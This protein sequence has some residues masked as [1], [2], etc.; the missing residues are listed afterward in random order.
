MI[1]KRIPK[2]Y[3]I[4]LDQG[5]ELFASLEVFTE[6]HQIQSAYV[7]G[8][9][10]VRELELGYFDSEQAQYERKIY[11]ENLEVV[12]L[13]GT[14][15]ECEDKPF[16]HIHG[17]FGTKQFETVGGHVMRAVTDMTLE[18]FISD[19]ETRITRTLDEQSG[20]KLLN[21]DRYA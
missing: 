11:Q 6:Q 10:L 12:S 17:V 7:S 20:L 8:I 16:Y 13:T 21:F 15:T 5:E 19:F 1:I 9:G 2:G 18:L 14:I 3:L 4:R